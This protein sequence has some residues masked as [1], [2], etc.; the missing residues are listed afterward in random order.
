[1]P[2]KEFE[3]LS[4][5]VKAH[6]LDIEGTH[7]VRL[8]LYDKS[9]TAVIH[10]L[11]ATEI[12][13]AED[14]IGAYVSA[15]V[16][17]KLTVKVSKYQKYYL[18]EKCNKLQDNNCKIL[19][20]K[21]ADFKKENAEDIPQADITLQG[22]K[23]H[24]E[25]AKQKIDEILS[26]LHHQ[27]VKKRHSQY[28]MMWKRKWE[29]VKAQEETN[30]NVVI[31]TWFDFDE[32]EKG[33]KSK[34]PKEV[35][36]SVEIAIIGDNLLLV[37]QVSHN[38]NGIA[39]TMTTRPILASRNQCKAV[40]DALKNK[41]LSLRESHNVELEIDWDKPELLLL[42]PS[43][44]S[45]DFEGASA[46]LLA[47][48]HGEAVKSDN[49]KLGEPALSNY[50]HQKQQW[51]EIIKVSRQSSVR[52]KHNNRVL[53]IS[54]KVPDVVK[55]KGLLEQ[56]LKTFSVHLGTQEVSVPSLYEPVLKT[57]EFQNLV[58]KLR[59]DLCVAVT[60]HNM[61]RSMNT[62][63]LCK[64]NIKPEGCD[65]PCFIE[66]CHGNLVN[67]TTDVVVNAANSELQHIGGLAKAISDAGGPAIQA[68]SD[69]YVRQNGIVKPGHL[70]CLPA[71]NLSCSVVMHAVGPIWKDGGHNKK[72]ELYA[73][74]STSLVESDK[75]GYRSISLPAIS[76][77]IYGCPVKEC[78]ALSI[79]A[80][81]D[82]LIGNCL[83]SVSHIRFVLFT[84]DAANAFQDS[85]KDC[86]QENK[87]FKATAEVV[88][89]PVLSSGEKAEWYWEDD[90][91][92]LQPYTTQVS[93][94][95][96][97]AYS[98]SPNQALMVQIEGQEYT[99][100]FAEMV[101]V[102]N[103]TQKRRRV[104][105]KTLGAVTWQYKDDNNCWTPY[106]AEYNDV[107]EAMYESKVPQRLDIGKWSYAIDFQNMEQINFATRKRRPIRRVAGNVAAPGKT[108]LKQPSVSASLSLNGPHQHLAQACKMIENY[109]EKCL[110]TC[111]VPLLDSSSY[112]AEK[113]KRLGHKYNVEAKYISQTKTVTFRGVSDSVTKARL[114][115][116]D[117]LLSVG[118]KS[119]VKFPPEW[120]TSDNSPNVEIV[121][122]KS[123]SQ[124]WRRVSQLVLSTLP[125]VNVLKIERVQNRWL[126][127]KYFLNC[128][129]MKDKNKGVIN[130]KELFHG[131]SGTSPDKVYADEEE[132][133]DMRFSRQGM[134][135]QGN[136]FAEK[137]EYSDNYAYQGHRGLKQLFL[138]KVLTGD[139]ILMKSDGSLRMPPLKTG[140]GNV[141][142]DTVCGD[143][144][145]C[146]V[147]IAY[148]NDKAYPFYL[149]TYKYKGFNVF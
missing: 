89:Q 21:L 92:R 20:P 149:I 34:K 118:S 42:A 24:V 16:E 28:A 95:L 101:Q 91:K 133:F 139:S 4:Q 60:F 128:K 83:K 140:G 141:R 13:S 134:W 49:I 99:I 72:E 39:D 38:I 77:G 135:G 148:S 26:S 105:R 51:S 86:L 98:V 85:F 146:R 25:V 10:G 131:T 54:G 29:E 41:K 87:N 37:C 120:E 9:N 48:I 52:V 96:S 107:L 65:R 68:Y 82:L 27:V 110:T 30:S 129:R 8:D 113:I 5:A 106:A 102:N 33:Q 46:T 100:Y 79:K 19:F 130:E 61:Q 50:I 93:A 104:H 6:V 70:A 17:V 88:A 125:Q 69:D 62:V 45:D 71:G 137:A 63:T 127:E 35:G 132:G 112:L 59:Q 97:H 7:K 12:N 116:Q 44:S 142:Y 138:A 47:F 53:E 22:E 144:H 90:A 2:K 78:A 56:L 119:N 108:L 121:E 1:M 73:A 64:A 122:V 15:N 143:T 114:A 3:C 124:E 111:E 123:T 23:C 11:T 136:Y 43:G 36:V 66:I 145:G 126:W 67:E 94:A 117:I 40:A 147:Y 31:F 32:K 14:E 80:I 74:V 57:L 109:F 103:K 115:A 81:A 58:S 18:T 76:A 55:A 84:W 75:R